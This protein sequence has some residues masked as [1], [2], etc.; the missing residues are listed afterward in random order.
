[1]TQS[2]PSKGN[3]T[4]PSSYQQGPVAREQE[5]WQ[6]RDEVG[7]GAQQPREGWVVFRKGVKKGGVE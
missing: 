6:Q 3:C 5:Q 1:M 7:S 4:C 2:V